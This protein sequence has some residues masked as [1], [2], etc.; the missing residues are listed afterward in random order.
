M[1]IRSPEDQFRD[2]LADRAARASGSAEP[3]APYLRKIRNRRVRNLFLSLV[4]VLA[5]SASGVAGVRYLGHARHQAPIGT[6]SDW[7]TFK[8]LGSAVF[9][10]PPN[11]FASEDHRIKDG[12]IIIGNRNETLTITGQPHSC[13]PHPPFPGYC[14]FI[15]FDFSQHDLGSRDVFVVLISRG[16]GKTYAARDMKSIHPPLAAPWHTPIGHNGV[17]FDLELLA[18]TNPSRDDMS[19]A[20]T[21]IRSLTFEDSK[22]PPLDTSSFYQVFDVAPIDAMNAFAVVSKTCVEAE[23]RKPCPGAILRTQDGGQTW[24]TMKSAPAFV[25]GDEPPLFPG[26]PF[27]ENRLFFATPQVG[28]LY[29]DRVYETR[30][31]GASW[32]IPTPIDSGVVS[33][34]SSGSRLWKIW[35]GNPE[36]S[37]VWVQTSRDLGTTWSASRTPDVAWRGGQIATINDSYAIMIERSSSKFGVDETT[38]GGM[39]WNP[40][41]IPP[42]CPVNDS[43]GHYAVGTINGSALLMCGANSGVGTMANET[44]YRLNGNR[45]SVVAQSILFPHGRTQIGSPPPSA[46][47]GMWS[48]GGRVFA[49]MSRA[50]LYTSTDGV[51]WRDTGIVGPDEEQI[52]DMQFVDSTHGWA[53]G[54]RSAWSTSDGGLTWVK[55]IFPTHIN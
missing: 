50:G 36:P 43:D 51:T 1:S 8:G 34:N 15:P 39:N 24:T 25:S 27:V 13:A 44:V 38:D 53:T 40:L 18:G 32:N 7:K 45:W 47:E 6:P 2:M 20:A 28:W 42:D 29:G 9:R 41:S 35:T 17:G 23:N 12:A 22:S 14:A 33:M 48:F 54:I 19:A 4:L 55:A 31:G 30:D 3:E 52:T 21:I 37:P 10:Y 46:V 26:P 11:W 49:E 16:P 5:V